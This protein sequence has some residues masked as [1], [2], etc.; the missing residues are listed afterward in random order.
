VRLGPQMVGLARLAPAVTIDA[1]N[2]ATDARQG[3]LPRRSLLGAQRLALS[4]SRVAPSL[5]GPAEQLNSHHTKQDQLPPPPH[6]HEASPIPTAT[7]KY[8]LLAS[9]FLFGAFFFF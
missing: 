8:G 7:A 1:L 5:P 9:D 2:A 4:G 3:D 6:E